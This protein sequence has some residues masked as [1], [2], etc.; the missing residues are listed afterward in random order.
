MENKEKFVKQ[1]TRIILT[2][3]PIIV[4]ALLLSAKVIKSSPI[5][6]ILIINLVSAA[7]LTIMSLESIL[8]CLFQ[9]WGKKKTIFS[10]IYEK[11]NNKRMIIFFA[12]SI[13][14]LLSTILTFLFTQ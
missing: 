1:I 9:I 3:L 5:S 12:S 7:I 10:K 11:I 13:V 14:F 6:F 2:D 8:N 4:G